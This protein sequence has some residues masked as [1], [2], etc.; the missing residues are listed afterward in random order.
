MCT[1]RTV[2]LGSGQSAHLAIDTAMV[3]GSCDGC[4]VDITCRPPDRGNWIETSRSARQAAAGEVPGRRNGIF[5]RGSRIETGESAVFWN[6]LGSPSARTRDP[7]SIAYASG[8][9]YY[10]IVQRRALS[11]KAERHDLPRTR[12]PSTRT[13]R[14]DLPAPR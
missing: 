4:Y 9:L 13:E 11:L 7:I 14:R 1:V 6:F 8:V 12:S 10:D 3:T 5:S 2:R